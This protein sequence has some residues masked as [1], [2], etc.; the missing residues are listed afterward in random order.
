MLVNDGEE[1]VTVSE[2]PICHRLFCAQCNVS[3]HEGT[4]CGEFK[5]LAKRDGTTSSEKEEKMVM[6]L[7]KNK[8]WR[9]CPG[10][11]IYVEKTEG[12]LHISCWSDI[13]LFI[14][15]LIFQ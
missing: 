14:Y 10:C 8:E 3:W 12:C 1:L 6:E 9:R 11:N 4:E 15:W 13:Y 2:C 7:A 5:R